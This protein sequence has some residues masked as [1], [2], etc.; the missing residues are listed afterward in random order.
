MRLAI[1]ARPSLG[2]RPRRAISATVILVAVL[3]VATLA[4]DRLFGGPSASSPAPAPPLPILKQSKPVE[5][6][7]GTTVELPEGKFLAAGIKVEA[8]ASVELPREFAATGRVEVDP[9]RRVEVRPRA[10]GVVRTIPVLPGTRVK[11]GDVLVVLDSPDIGSARLKV[12]ERQRDLATAR[13]EADRKATIAAN[14]ELM[15]LRFAQGASAKEVAKDFTGKP[16]GNA[17]GTLVS[18]WKDLELA[19]HEFEKMNDLNKKKIVGEHVVFVAEHT[20]EGA[21]AIFDS[22]L[23]TTRYDVQIADRLAKQAVRNAEEMVVD[24]AQRLRLLGVS[25]DIG[26]LLAHPERAS[27]LPSGSEDLTGYPIVAAIDGTVLST[28]TARSQRVDPTDLLF[29]LADLSVVHAVANIPESQFA[30]LPGLGFGSRVSLATQALPDRTFEA[31]ILYVNSDVDPATRTIR[32]VAEVAN[33][34]GILILNM[35]ARILFDTRSI[36]RVVAVPTA[37][38]VLLEEKGQARPAVFIPVTGGDHAFARRPVQLGRE[39][40]GRR[41]IL[42]GLAAGDRVVTTGAFLLKSELMLQNE[43]EEE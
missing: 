13:V 7:R 33:P 38:I 11:A 15:V 27:A 31:K 39:V 9:N 28:T 1:P 18:A 36:D 17:R 41:V 2:S 23:D 22:A 6:D 25:E 16:M 10:Q 40:G 12:R 34:E 21:Q 4:H 3:A 30:A 29:V 37:S 24:A 5:I 19:S 42:D 26:E 14:V 35:F 20:Q 32:L 43:T 8:A